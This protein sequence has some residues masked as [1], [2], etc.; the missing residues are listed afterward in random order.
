MS[1]ETKPQDSA[2]MSPASAGSVADVYFSY[3]D[4]NEEIQHCKVAAADAGRLLGD[5]MTLVYRLRRAA[6]ELA[7]IADS[8][9]DPVSR[10]QSL[11][12]M[13]MD[14]FAENG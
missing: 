10:R 11:H 3:R 13:A 5:A 8:D 1:D 4:I 12:R 7:E 6:A 14:S 2:A 9:S